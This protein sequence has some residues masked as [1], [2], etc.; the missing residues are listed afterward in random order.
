MQ[1]NHTRE[2]TAIFVLW[3]RTYQNPHKTILYLLRLRYGGG[4][5]NPNRSRLRPSAISIGCCVRRLLHQIVVGSMLT[6]T[7]V[8]NATMPVSG[9][10]L[11]GRNVL[12]CQVA[13]VIVA[14]FALDLDERCHN[15]VRHGLV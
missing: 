15:L 4:R 2:W 6:C 8:S 14:A 10:T 11:L 13:A 9:T 12:S 7:Q 5:G 1:P 3:L